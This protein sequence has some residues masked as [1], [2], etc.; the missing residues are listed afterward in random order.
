MHEQRLVN[1]DAILG[2][3]FEVLESLSK[4][5]GELMKVIRAAH[6]FTTTSYVRW[7][8]EEER[9]NEF[10]NLNRCAFFRVQ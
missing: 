1:Q 6:D 9:T 3:T 2:K 5:H 8:G 10:G 4:K 7:H